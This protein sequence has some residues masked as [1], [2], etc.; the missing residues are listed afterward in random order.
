MEKMVSTAL[1]AEMRQKGVITQNE[2]LYE[3][4]DLYVAEDV[5]TR[6]R[7]VVQEVSS[8]MTEGR[9]VLKG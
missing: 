4:G 3:V 8:F 7:R 2:V 9:R 5:V 1:I 6:Q